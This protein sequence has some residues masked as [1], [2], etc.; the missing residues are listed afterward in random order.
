[1]KRRKKVSGSEQTRKSW[2]YPGDKLNR[3]LLGHAAGLAPTRKGIRRRTR[4]SRAGL[5]A[6]H[7]VDGDLK[8]YSVQNIRTF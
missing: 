4:W 8:I 3:N 2:R 5:R 6:L 1:M 7:Q